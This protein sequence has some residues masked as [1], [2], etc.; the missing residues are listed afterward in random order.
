M[1]SSL[2]SETFEERAMRAAQDTYRLL[3]GWNECQ[4]EEWGGHDL[5]RDEAITLLEISYYLMGY[6]ES[7]RDFRRPMQRRFFDCEENDPARRA[8]RLARALRSPELKA[9]YEDAYERALEMADI[10]T[11]FAEQCEAEEELLRKEEAAKRLE[12]APF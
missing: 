2:Q 1:K 5:T 12:R 4:T 6:L 3:A 7:V 8:K 10:F 9:I 11:E